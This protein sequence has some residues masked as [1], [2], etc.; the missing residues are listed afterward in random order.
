MAK[1]LV[2]DKDR[3]KTDE[4]LN[5]FLLWGYNTF[6]AN[7]KEDAINK[8]KA[9]SFN[10]IFI[11][12]SILEEEPVNTIESISSYAVNVPLVITSSLSRAKLIYLIEKVKD[13]IVDIVRKPY[14][15]DKLIFLIENLLAGTEK[16]TTKE[17]G[18]KKVLTIKERKDLRK[19]KHEAFLKEQLA[20]LVKEES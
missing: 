11:D 12:E 3:N 8:L 10:I 5:S 15:I 14:S 19:K 1:I 17:K 13:S 20:K 7:T 2:I 9:T 18:Y 4:I 16:Q 6:I